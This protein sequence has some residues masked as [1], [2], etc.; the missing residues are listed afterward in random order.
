VVFLTLEDET[1][2]ADVAVP[3]DVFRCFQHV[4]RLSPALRIR[5]RMTTDGRA[6][7]LSALQIAPLP[8][9]RDIPIDSH[10]FH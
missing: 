1:G 5:G 4:I 2:H 6:H 10:D 8:F 3:A 9:E 7:T